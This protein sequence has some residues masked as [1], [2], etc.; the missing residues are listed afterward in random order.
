MS[1]APFQ[2]SVE[3]GKA[4]AKSA[5]DGY[6]ARM[7]SAE[8]GIRTVREMN[9]GNG[10]VGGGNRSTLKYRQL[11]QDVLVGMHAIVPKPKCYSPRPCA[12]TLV[13]LLA[14]VDID[15]GSW[16]TAS[17]PTLLVANT[18]YM[19]GNASALAFRQKL[20]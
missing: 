17:Y 6:Q 14:R 20:F 3:G 16:C 9:S 18:T 2:P 15:S 7:L 19:E 5:G 4:C 13:L 12:S 8:L 10:I 11:E 1:N